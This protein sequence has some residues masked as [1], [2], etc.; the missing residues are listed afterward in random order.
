MKNITAVIRSNRERLGWSQEEAAARLG[1][2]QVQFHYWESGRVFPNYKQMQLMAIVFDAD[3]DLVDALTYS[4]IKQTE[5]ELLSHKGVTI[6]KYVK[7]R[8][9][10]IESLIR[11]QQHYLAFLAPKT[12]DTPSKGEV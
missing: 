5:E 9:K 1:V 3:S 10:I 12:E 4:F 11:N 8:E 2:S 6:E 7:L